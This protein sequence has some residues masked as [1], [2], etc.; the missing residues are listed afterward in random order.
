M[1]R[2]RA[3]ARPEDEASCRKELEEIEREGDRLLIAEQTCLTPT[4]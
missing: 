4:G 3:V 1:G 2:S